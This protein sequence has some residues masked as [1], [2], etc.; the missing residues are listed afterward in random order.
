MQHYRCKALWKSNFATG[1]CGGLRDRALLLLLATGGIEPGAAGASLDV[2]H[3]RV[4]SG[5]GL[6]LLG[7]MTAP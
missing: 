4:T 2:V 5:T 3:R 1:S 6:T 7:L